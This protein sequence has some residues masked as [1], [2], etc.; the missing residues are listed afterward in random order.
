MPFPDA[1]RAEVTEDKV[2]DYLLNPNHPVGGPKAAW[3]ASIGYSIDNWQDLVDDLRMLARS[4]D[5]FVAK[6][7]R[8]GVKYEVAGRIGRPGHRPADVITV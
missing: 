8:F 5:D 3:F 4:V 2:R 1:E 7:S 6:R